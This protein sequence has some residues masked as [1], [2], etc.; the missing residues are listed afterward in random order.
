MPRGS[1]RSSACDRIVIPTSAG[2]GS[3]VGFL[4]A[5]VAY[6]VVRSRFFRLSGFD[7][8]A[9]NAML[10]EMQDEARADR[11]DRRAR[12]GD[13]RAP[14]CRHALHRPGP[15]DRGRPAAARRSRPTTRRSCASC[16]RSAMPRS[17]A[18]PMPGRRSRDPELVGH[19]ERLGRPARSAIRRCRRELRAR[20]DDRRGCSTRLLGECERCGRPLA[21]RAG[22]GQPHRGPGASSPRT[23]TAT[24][25]SGGLRRPHR[26]LRPYRPGATAA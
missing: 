16:S 3:A 10:R 7:S 1:P 18:A 2:V 5:P 19:R 25:V 8:A 12:S 6:E 24:V 23:Q 14:P 9:V 17:S 22:A 20:R 26:S 21:R 4:R 11:G 15:R 13:R